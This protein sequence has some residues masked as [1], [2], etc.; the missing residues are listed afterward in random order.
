MDWEEFCETLEA[1]LAALPEPEELTMIVQFH[2]ILE[3]LALVIKAPLQN[4]YQCQNPVHTRGH[5]K[6]D[7][8]E[9]G[10]KVIWEASSG[11]HYTKPHIPVGFRSESGIRS[12]FLEFQDIPFTYIF[13]YNI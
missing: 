3:Q 8:G 5:T 2:A 4:M 7:E 10:K 13:P 6:E 11:V 9:A 12:E 1:G